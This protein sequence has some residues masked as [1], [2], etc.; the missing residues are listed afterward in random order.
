MS[1]CVYDAPT[2]ISLFYLFPPWSKINKIASEKR[3][4]TEQWAIRRSNRVTEGSS[5][6]NYIYD[7]FATRFLSFFPAK[8]KETKETRR[9]REHEKRSRFSDRIAEM[10]DDDEEKA[11]QTGKICSAVNSRWR[12][13]GKVKDEEGISS[14]RRICLFCACSSTLIY[15]LRKIWLITV[16]FNTGV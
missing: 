5:T 15:Y 7:F 10:S 13:M 8:S 11:E 6:Q 16:S 14:F 1:S 3:K 2:P 9:P 12:P 4:L